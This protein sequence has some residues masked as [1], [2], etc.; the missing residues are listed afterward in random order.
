[1]RGSPGCRCRTASTRRPRARSSTRSSAPR[2]RSPRGRARRWLPW[3]EARS[4]VASL[5]DDEAAELVA[6]ITLVTGAAVPRVRGAAAGM[7][8]AVP[9]EGRD[10]GV[11]GGRR[12]RRGD[13]RAAQDHRNR[14]G[15]GQRVARARLVDRLARRRARHDGARRRA[16]AGAD[17]RPPLPEAGRSRVRSS[18]SPPGSSRRTCS[19]SRRTASRSSATCRAGCRRPSCRASTWSRST[20]RRSS[21]RRSRCCSSGSRRPRGTPA[22][23][24][25][26]TSTRSTSIRNRWRRAWRTSARASSRACRSRRASPPAR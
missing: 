2:A 19:T 14:R 10:H 22:R 15:R 24:P 12:R 18:S 20:S 25:R 21:W 1:M 17:P 26:G 7:D 6:A 8:L 11:P 16:R 9:L 4:L 5:A 13:R 23:S 3:R